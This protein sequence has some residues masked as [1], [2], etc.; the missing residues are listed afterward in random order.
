MR[1]KLKHALSNRYALTAV[2]FLAIT[3]WGTVT[4]ALG[5][6]DQ[7][8]ACAGYK[9]P[10]AR[11][12]MVKSDPTSPERPPRTAAVTT[13]DAP[14]DAASWPRRLSAATAEAERA[15]TKALE[16]D[17]SLIQ[18]YGLYQRLVDRT[19]VEDPADSQYAVMK[20]PDGTLTFA[21]QGE[22]DPK[23]QAAELK[24]LQT[25]LA[26]QDVSLLY[27]QAP[28]KQEPGTNRLPTG[29]EDS[30]N[31][32]A[33]ALLAELEAMGVDHIDFRK[34]LQQAGGDW[35]HWFYTTDHHWTQEAAFLCFGQ[36]CEK[37]AGYTQT[38][39]VSW[40]SKT[41]PISIPAQYTDPASYA[42]A[43]LPR[44]F[45]GSHG[46]RVG[47]LYGGAD[48]FLLHTP[49][50]PTLL[51]Y[52]AGSDGQR[53]G[54]LEDTVLFPQRVETRRWFDATPYEYYAGGDYPVASVDNYYAPDGPRILLIRDSY[55]NAMTPYLS[56]VSSHLTTIDPRHFSGDL[57]EYIHYDRPDVV[58]ILYSSG[59]V[60]EETYY[61]LL[62]QPTP[63]KGDA[64][65]WKEDET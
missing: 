7:R 6:L 36:V 10:F 12:A 24:R 64:L 41:R 61:R 32:C 51:H 58:L 50:F 30:S 2:L 3:L 63:S 49:K 26:Q 29:V 25:A 62:A 60:R 40:G 33:D 57:L 14:G 43:T 45:L 56:L 59:M 48:D 46:K 34:T 65:M 21:G 38:L 15:V 31:R 1:Y 23:A 22:P 35:S 39:S 55:A 28:S 37:L 19:V 4:V 17:H 8:T 5:V 18:L 20:L 9:V 52:S 16:E 47:F 53:Y 54:A 44:F 27:L 42:T 11:T 13:L